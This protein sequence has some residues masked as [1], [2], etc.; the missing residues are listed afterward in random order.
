MKF[1]EMDPSTTF[2][3]QLASADSH[4]VVLIN[5]F[6]VPPGFE[7]DFLELWQED[8]AFMLDHGCLGAQMHKGTEGSTSFVNIAL[9][10]NAQ[11]IAK[12]FASEEF[13]SLIARYPDTCT[14]S[15][16]LFTRIAVPGV[17]VA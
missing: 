15:P 3:Q 5:R 16:H 11:A 12:A 17:C 13:Q 1:V 14:I 6:S 2:R 7:P 8:A 9:W 10:E 4:P